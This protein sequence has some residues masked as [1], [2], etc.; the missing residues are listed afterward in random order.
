[1]NY[2]LSELS[3]EDIEAIT[4]QI[5]KTAKTNQI[6]LITYLLICLGLR[7]NEFIILTYGDF[8]WEQ[9]MLSIK[10]THQHPTRLIPLN[11]EF[12]ERM[13]QHVK[14]MDNPE[15]DYLFLTKFNNPFCQIVITQMMRKLVN[16]AG[17]GDLYC[18]ELYKL[19]WIT[20]FAKTYPTCLRDLT[21]ILR[22]KSQAE[23]LFLARS[24][25]AHMYLQNKDI[26]RI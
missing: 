17:Y 26:G 12:L 2:L 19:C 20:H 15:E 6:W 3:L 7:P 8:L 5:L 1:M 4:L 22:F 25:K 24:I 10:E 14:E 16:K 13:Q 21:K 23:V 11:E 9:G 18:R